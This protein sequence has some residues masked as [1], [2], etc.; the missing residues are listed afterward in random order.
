MLW[1]QIT[2][3]CLRAA[4]AG[5]FSLRFIPG[6]QDYCLRRPENSPVLPADVD[7]AYRRLMR[8]TP[9]LAAPPVS[10]HRLRPLC[11]Q[12]MLRASATAS[13]GRVLGV[14]NKRQRSHLPLRIAAGA[15]TGNLT[16]SRSQPRRRCRGALLVQ[17]ADC[18]SG[19]PAPAAAA[20]TN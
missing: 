17:Y 13:P 3:Y 15:A 18:R 12:T 7:A 20:S 11:P 4:T 10:R 14:N 16:C 6:W 9:L 1:L 8:S 19:A 2:F 5:T